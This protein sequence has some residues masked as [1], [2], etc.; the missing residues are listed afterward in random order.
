MS[1][2]WQINKQ[3]PG[4]EAKTEWQYRLYYNDDGSIVKYST[5]NEPGKYIVI[6]KSEYAQGRYDVRV[7]NGQIEHL[8]KI[9]EYR[10]LI[11]SNQ[12][13]ETAVDDVTI[14]TQ[15]QHWDMKYYD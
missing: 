3:H 7:K 10:K 2:F 12:G 8:N 14:V 4:A 11:P 6:S 1:N 15:G 5:D 9:T 13:I